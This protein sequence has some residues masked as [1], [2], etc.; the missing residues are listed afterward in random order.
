VL[1]TAILAPVN[2]PQLIPVRSPAGSDTWSNGVAGV[3]H[4]GGVGVGG[5]DGGGVDVKGGG[6]GG[7][8]DGGGGDGGGGD[9]PLYM[10][11]GVGADWG[12]RATPSPSSP[13]KEQVM[14]CVAMC[15]VVVNV[16]C[17]AWSLMLCVWCGR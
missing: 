1:G 5:V 2:P 13:R 9:G 6:E 17:V 14:L 7:G 10:R 3:V 8:G 4:G 15:G 12:D 11:A 16:V